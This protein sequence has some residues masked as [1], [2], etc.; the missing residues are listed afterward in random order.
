MT[1]TRIDT[2]DGKSLAV[3][4]NFTAHP[5]FMLAEQMM[6]SGDWPGHLQRTLESL[7]GQDT[8]VMYYNGAE[9]DQAPTARSVAGNSRWEKAEYYGRDLGIIAWDLWKKTTVSKDVPFEFHRQVIDLPPTSWHP[10]FM[11]TGGAEYGLNEKILTEMLPKMFPKKTA[12]VSVRLGDLLI[13]GVPG[14]MIAEL[15]RTIKQE[16]GKRTGAAHP[17]IGGLADEWDSYILT[18]PEYRS[19]GGYEASMSFYGETLG[20]TILDGTLKGIDQHQ[21]KASA[22]EPAKPATSQKSDPSKKLRVAVAQMRSSRNIAEN[23]AKT[24]DFLAKAARQKA[25]VVVFPEC[26]LSGYFDN[27]YMQSLNPEALADA[28]RQVADA[29][30]EHNVY[31]LIGNPTPVEGKLYNSA[32]VFDPSGKTLERYHKMKLAENWP[33]SGDHLSVFQIDNVPCSI[34]VCHDERYPELVRLPVMAGSRVVF[35]LSHESGIK[36]EKKIA[37]YRAQIQARAVENS[38]YVLHANAPANPD[39]SGSHGQ[40]R[41]IDPDGNIVQEGS[42]FEE[43]LIVQ[44]IDLQKSTGRMAQL[45]LSSGALGDW[46]RTGL[47]QVRMISQ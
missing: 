26:S 7:I 23:V 47:Q 30:R 39:T 16:T 37:P 45:G 22:A 5:T 21:K 40:S 11:E 35:Y 43:D 36:N 17:V 18:A 4:V 41:V 31:A 15:G 44:T 25:R 28:E 33:I 6:F 34:I 29:C 1:L 8:T 24:R 20:Q 10:K 46:Y 32:I 9:G 42:I 3:L 12:S 2:L 19:G 38:V 14:E 13:V 27:A